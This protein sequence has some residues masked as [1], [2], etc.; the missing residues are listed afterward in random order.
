[1]GNSLIAKKFAQLVYELGD[2][3]EEVTK[4]LNGPILFVLDEARSMLTRN[5]A[6]VLT[7]TGT[8]TT[9]YVQRLDTYENVNLVTEIAQRPSLAMTA[10][11]ATNQPPPSTHC[12]ISEVT[13]QLQFSAQ[14]G[15]RSSRFGRAA[16][17]SFL[18]NP[19][20]TVRDYQHF[21]RESS[22]RFYIW[23]R[24]LSRMAGVDMFNVILDTSSK[25]SNFMPNAAIDPSDRLV[26]GAAVLLPPF[27]NIRGPG[28]FKFLDQK[29]ELADL[30]LQYEISDEH[31][32][33]EV[34]LFSIFEN[35][36]A[37]FF[38][39]LL[40][41]D[42]KL[43]KDL[44]KLEKGETQVNLTW[45]DVDKQWNMYLR[46][47]RLAVYKMGLTGNT[48]DL[49]ALMA[50]FSARIGML[51][52][53]SKSMDDL[54]ASYMAFLTHIDPRRISLLAKYPVEPMIAE[55]AAYIMNSVSNLVWE[56]CNAL[57]NMI[58][59]NEFRAFISRGDIAE[60]TLSF[61]LCLIKDRLL[62]GMI[63]NIVVSLS[64]PEFQ[65]VR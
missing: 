40:E 61:I 38:K 62:T 5:V 24:A 13:T 28:H 29:P 11:S 4:K 58:Y 25:V 46:V 50:I 47:R 26:T 30:R 48:F 10:I 56:M 8:P 54:V 65:F 21:F 34:R 55:A 32:R 14:T 17:S 6:D 41:L 3:Y 33:L 63:T 59:G 12:Q 44:M 22:A 51:P 43:Q 64:D 2:L 23:R 42:S 36:R 45:F 53:T 52:F 9:E 35:S 7:Q 27:Y 16:Q 39:E 19:P 15:L 49:K 18:E 31:K 60:M 1:M 37:L 20:K 57:Q